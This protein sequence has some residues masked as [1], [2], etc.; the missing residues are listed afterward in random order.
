MYE[1]DNIESAEIQ[2]VAEPETENALESAETQEVAEP[3][4]ADSSNEEAESTEAESEPEQPAG[5]TE[6]DAAFAE[7]RREIARLK[8]ENEMMHGALGRY[9][10]GETAEEL[11]I[12][13]NAY[14]ED[15]DPDEYREQW[16]REQE[17]ESTQAE[18]EA[19]RERLTEMEIDRRM[20]D[21]LREVQAIDP[22]IK[23]LDELGDTFI[24]LIAAG[25]DTKTAY[26]G[27]M[28]ERRQE[29]VFAPEAIG[30]AGDSK[31]E[32]DYFTSDEIDALTDEELYDDAT[33]DKVMRSLER[34]K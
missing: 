12:N 15:R 21:G 2:E 8:R 9:F 33:W 11:S 25:L 32:R 26:Y 28:A 18:N 5:R 24:K 3:V 34:L 14:A 20:Q 17:Y 6:Q 16:E 29:K 4:E 31:N 27:S 10:D 7:Q 1:N 19:L 13:A 30:R 23:S 22:N